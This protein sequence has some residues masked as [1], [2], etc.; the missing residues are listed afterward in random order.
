MLKIG[1]DWVH[2]RTLWLMRN[3]IDLHT[4]SHALIW[5]TFRLF[6]FCL[7]F[8]LLNLTLRWEKCFCGPLKPLK[9]ILL[10]TGHFY[11]LSMS[12][13]FCLCTW[14]T[15]ILALSVNKT[16]WKK[17]LT[18]AVYFQ[19]KTSWT[20][21]TIFSSIAETILSQQ[22]MWSCQMLACTTWNLGIWGSNPAHDPFALP[23]LLNTLKWNICSGARPGWF[24]F[25]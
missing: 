19:S 1:K 11:F 13:M 2:C 20:N 3:Q 6:L 4:F 16:T 9:Y 18:N 15:F 23:H 17:M 7:F 22:S 8:Y 10:L 24:T 25:I 12:C 5:I 14:I 21:I